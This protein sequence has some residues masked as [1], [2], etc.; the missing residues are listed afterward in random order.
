MSNESQKPNCARTPDNA[1]SNKTSKSAQVPQQQAN[2]STLKK[3]RRAWNSFEI[4]LIKAADA[5]KVDPRKASNGNAANTSESRQKE[6]A[7]KSVQLIKSR[8]EL[9]NLLNEAEANVKDNAKE[10]KALNLMSKSS[11][12]CIGRGTRKRRRSCKS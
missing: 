2:Q 12:N 7:N 9:R 1:G 11:G 10:F 3:I 4:L 6:V 5:S 8:L